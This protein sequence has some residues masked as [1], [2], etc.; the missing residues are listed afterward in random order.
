MN[1]RSR[2]A[3]IVT[4]LLGALTVTYTASASTFFIPDGDTSALLQL[5]VNG[6]QQ[7]NTLNEQ[8]GTL[9]RTYSETKKLAGYAED[10]VA[11]FRGIAHADLSGAVQLLED[12]VPNLRYFDREAHHL[13]SWTQ[14]RGE[15]KWL[16]RACLRARQR[17]IEAQAKDQQMQENWAT[18][19]DGSPY[20]A[21]DDRAT[22]AAGLRA[23]QA[24][25]ELDRQVSGERLAELIVR[26]FGPPRTP[27]QLRADQVAADALGD[28]EALYWRDK[29]LEQDW[30]GYEDYCFTAA[31]GGLMAELD[32]SIM[33]RCQAAE[34]LVQLRSAR[35][36]QILR[37][38]VRRLK[39]I[40]AYR[41]LGENAVRKRE[42][43][44]RAREQ[45]QVLDGAQHMA[46]PEIRVT[47]PG[48]NLEGDQ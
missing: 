48:F 43:D 28:S 12:A 37:G 21:A 31:K 4:M 7:L 10:A 30:K 41:L 25:G 42:T 40:E 20:P 29:T 26:D 1:R 2:K 32:D 46:A 44:D 3:L 27:A 22:V 36:M 38:E 8:L 33:E 17:Q 13:N 16:V 19:T 11:A 24:C 18:N 5:L 34:V 35:E 6:M 45:Q 14:G 39:D 9:R 23:D 15:L 47:A